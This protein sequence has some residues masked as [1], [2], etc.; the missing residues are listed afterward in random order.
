MIYDLSVLVRPIFRPIG[1]NAGTL[2]VT[3]IM[4]ANVIARD[5]IPGL[6]TS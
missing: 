1:D 6:T 4:T 5:N 2:W 3:I